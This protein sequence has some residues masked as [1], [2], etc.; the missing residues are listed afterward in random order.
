MAEHLDAPALE[1]PPVVRFRDGDGECARG[2]RRLGRGG[3]R[4]QKPGDPQGAARRPARGRPC[5]PPQVARPR[6]QAAT[7][8]A[9]GR[10]FR[11]RR[12]ERA[13]RGRTDADP[14]GARQ[15]DRRR[16]RA[17]SRI[18]RCGLPP[19]RSRRRRAGRNPRSYAGGRARRAEARPRLSRGLGRAADAERLHRRAALLER[20]PDH[21]PYARQRGPARDLLRTL[22][23]RRAAIV[24]SAPS[25]STAC[26]APSARPASRTC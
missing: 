23:R 8:R 6:R 18:R 3:R 13:R 19:R 7:D 24:S 17:R 16:G 11:L 10:R 15:R 25:R 21:R 26:C 5:R 2:I 14:R 20:R 1:A 9:D 4:G 12:A 22:C